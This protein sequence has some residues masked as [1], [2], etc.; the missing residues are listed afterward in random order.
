MTN[1]PRTIEQ[2]AVDILKSALT[3]EPDSR[4][5]ANVSAHEVIKLAAREVL[6]CPRCGA[7]PWCNIDC[8]VC[9]VVGQIVIGEIP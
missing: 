4:L 9:L 1:K 2:I 5:I 6:S 7:E 3:H 8:D